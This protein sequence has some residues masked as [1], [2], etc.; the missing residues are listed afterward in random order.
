[1]DTR[2][3]EFDEDEDMESAGVYRS[4][5]AKQR[6][7]K[8]SEDTEDLEEESSRNNFNSINSEDNNEQQT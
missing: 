8:V 4:G 6:K 3:D 7:R 5:G 2:E 1:L